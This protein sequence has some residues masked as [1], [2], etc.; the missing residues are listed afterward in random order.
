L[1]THI[2]FG[3][4]LADLPYG[5]TDLPALE[6]QLGA[7][8]GV[9][10]AFVD[11]SYVIGGANELWMA[12]WGARKVLLA[13]EPNGI[14]FTDVT[15]GSQDAYLQRV[16]NSMKAFPYDVYVRP[17]PE[18]NGHWSTW[19]PTAAGDKPDGG[20]PAQFVDA[21]RYLVDFM[22]SRGVTHLKFVFNPDASNQSIDTPISSIWPGATYVDVL[23]IDG[24]NWG[25]SA[26]G[27][28]DTGDRW[29]SFS[30]I[31]APMYGVLT[32]LS[33]TS[34]VWITEF[35]SKEPAEEDDSAY[36]TESSPIDPTHDKGTWINDLMASTTFPRVAALVYFNQ[37]KER[38][39][40]LDSS[41]SSLDAIRRAL[42]SMP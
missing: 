36:P 26:L 41:T 15:N 3:A 42:A 37:K 33:G 17:W 29:Q 25:N 31:F 5:R 12:N 18:M 39:W 19:Q 28:L 13:W 24:Y 14:R 8:V 34:P 27:P 35:G 2:A 20:T 11:W 23:G 9:A 10:S 40:R 4:T 38:D 30:D 1:V 16:A 21:W 6:T 22:R 7:P 32:M